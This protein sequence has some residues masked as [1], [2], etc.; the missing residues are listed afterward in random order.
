[1]YG[2]IYCAENIA[3]GKKYI[4]QTTRPLQTRWRAHL[5]EAKRNK[6]RMPICAAIR[7]YGHDLFFVRQ[8]AWARNQK[9]LDK[10]E[11]FFIDFWGTLSPGKGYNARE[12]GGFGKLTLEARK[13]MSDSRKGEK[14]WAYGKKRSKHHQEKLNEARRRRGPCSDATRKKLSETG[15]KRIWSEETRKK[16]S[17]ARAGHKMP[18]HVKQALRLANAGRPSHLRKSVICLTTGDIFSSQREAA[19]FAGV[20]C[21]QM[22]R[23]LNGK[24]LP[25]S[26][27][28]F[29]RCTIADSA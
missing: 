6:L 2:I 5:Y 14:H 1:M 8:I 13:R 15:K 9:E 22:S 18:E 20:S 16:I 26:G 10:Q 3:N 27:L 28:V 11:K 12:G 29:E 19:S 24:N 21:A 23:I 17:S 25:R 7:K 4:G